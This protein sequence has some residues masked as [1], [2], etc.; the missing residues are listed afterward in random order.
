ML[1]LGDAR[2]GLNC[3]TEALA[4]YEV[5]LTRARATAVP[6]LTA[7]ALFGSARAKAAAGDSAG[8]LTAAAESQAL[9]ATIGHR[10]TRRLQRW[11]ADSGKNLLPS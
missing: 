2:L 10:G 11:L 9:F 4:A 8:A 7:E 1:A 3:W 6:E 5:L